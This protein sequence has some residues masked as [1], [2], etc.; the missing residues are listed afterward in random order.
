[1]IKYVLVAIAIF[2]LGIVSPVFAHEPNFDIN[3]SRDILKLCNFFYEEYDLLGKENFLD[4]HK[5][6]VNSKICSIL[7]ENV[8]WNSNHPQKN[9]VLIS[10]IEKKLS[11]NSNY[12]KE[13]HL[14]SS[15]IPK[16]FEKKAKLWVAGEIKNSEF[17]SAVK[18]M[19]GKEFSSQK[20]MK[21]DRVCSNIDSC[22]KEKDYVEY[23]YTD[24]KGR[25]EIIKFE[26]LEIISRETV[27]GAEPKQY[28]I[29]I[30][31]EKNNKKKHTLLKL[32]KSNRMAETFHDFYL[33]RL[34]FSV[35]I[36]LNETIEDGFQV[37]DKTE[38]GT[39]DMTRD[40]YSA[41]NQE[42]KS[43]VIDKQTGLVLSLEYSNP[44]LDE[45]FELKLE[46][47]NIFESVMFVE[48]EQSIPKWFKHNVQWYLDETITQD[49]FVQSIKHL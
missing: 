19:S 35:P 42:G 2:S 34:V 11:E 15:L 12:L 9:Y 21:F 4:H 31:S 28:T 26:V 1:M 29:G 47:T 20:E 43:V 37:T 45:Y 41:H 13:K 27:L 5:L 33:E 8:A 18:Q 10:E 46:K 40:G 49:E 39:N 30:E 3:S 24:N 17:L 22:L 44:I 7:Y 16:S 32:D 25:K 36:Y 23:S 14:D 48:S 38:F 6:L